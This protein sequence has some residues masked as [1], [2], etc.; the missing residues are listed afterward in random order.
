MKRY[1][2]K[3]SGDWHAMLLRSRDLKI[4]VSKKG[5]PDR[6]ISPEIQDDVFG[7]DKKA[8]ASSK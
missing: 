7:K 6:R 8:D 2:R 3:T 4:A 1:W 5:G